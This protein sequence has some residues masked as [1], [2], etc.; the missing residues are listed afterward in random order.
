MSIDLGEIKDWPREQLLEYL[1]FLLHNYRVMD[2]FW[3]INLEDKYGQE[4]AC[5]VN[6]QVWGKVGALA[7]RDLKKRFNLTQGGL[8]GFLAAKKIYPWSLLVGYQYRW[9][10]GGL[11][12]EVPSCPPQEARL[13]RGQ[14]EYSCQAMHRAE[15]E[16]FASEIDPRIKVECIFAPPG[17]HPPELFCRW[18]L[19]LEE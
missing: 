4:E 3:F 8:E 15:F 9:E 14:G 1:G 17:Q 11:I 7:A 13:K 19:S 2:G 18:R 6:E 16:G 10:D 5:R 12:I